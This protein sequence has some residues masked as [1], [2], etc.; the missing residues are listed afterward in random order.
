MNYAVQSATVLPRRKWKNNEE[1]LA[2]IQ[3][4]GVSHIH[5]VQLQLY[6][7]HAYIA[8]RRAGACNVL[9]MTWR[10]K[11]NRMLCFEVH[12]TCLFLSDSHFP[13]C[14]PFSRSAVRSIHFKNIS[15]KTENADFHQR[16]N[17]DRAGMLLML[18]F[19]F[20]FSYRRSFRA[21]H[22][23]EDART[24]S[25][26][27]LF[28][29]LGN[30][31]D[32]MVSHNDFSRA[33][34]STD[35]PA[36]QRAVVGAVL[37]SSFNTIR[38]VFFS[39]LLLCCERGIIRLINYKIRSPKRRCQTQTTQTELVRESNAAFTTITRYYYVFR[40]ELLRIFIT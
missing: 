26:L 34:C 15:S 31:G 7:V 16:C 23:F 22:R 39:L 36:N 27:S 2:H 10:G 18:R 3:P 29:I 32:N 38:H 24:P 4:I 12:Q 11:C 37:S 19:L 13:I 28:S 6:T 25:A 14:F 8:H 20:A 30:N 1:I 40:V 5:L 21:L 33:S 17:V 9:L 35:E